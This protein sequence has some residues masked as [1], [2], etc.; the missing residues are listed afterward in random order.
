MEKNK[1]RNLFEFIV[2]YIKNLRNFKM[3]KML[4]VLPIFL[5]TQFLNANSISIQKSR[6][7][8]D[9]YADENDLKVTG[10]FKK[11]NITVVPS[12]E[13]INR[14]GLNDKQIGVEIYSTIG[15][16]E[17]KTY[18]YIAGYYAPSNEFLPNYDISASIHKGI[19]SS[20]IFFG[21]KRMGFDSKKVDIYKTGIILPASRGF[22]ISEKFS[23]VP[24]DKTYLLE[25]KIL[26]DN[27]SNIKAY[28]SYGFGNTAED[29]LYA[30]VKK[31]D[32]ETH[33]LGIKYKINDDIYL[34]A[35]FL[36][37]YLENTYKKTGGLIFI[38]YVW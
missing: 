16:K 24:K 38:D 1:S 35:E 14:Y 5:Y 22:S 12:V 6:Y 3:K 7:T 13:D 17:L 32:I 21:V 11:G 30:G 37:E 15:D 27:E 34:G 4:L 26:Y 36:K 9:K 8:Y 33:I 10:V 31:T 20:E 2:K 29:L 18:G 25:S 28:Y 23:Y 19:Y